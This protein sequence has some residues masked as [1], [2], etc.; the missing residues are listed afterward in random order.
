MSLI[1]PT[2][3]KLTLTGQLENGENISFYY[4]SS[5]SI[6]L[7]GILWCGDYFYSIMGGISKVKIEENI[8]LF[9][10]TL[11]ILPLDNLPKSSR[12]KIWR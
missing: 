9:N 2:G 12:I 1:N 7:A 5:G 4:H 8:Y 10:P 3:I 11:N 6:Y